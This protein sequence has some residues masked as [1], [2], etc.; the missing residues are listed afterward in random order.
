MAR[1]ARIK[2]R[3]KVMP[4]DVQHSQTE[5]PTARAL[6]ESDPD[7]TRVWIDKSKRQIRYSRWSTDLRYVHQ[8]PGKAFSFVG[9]FDG[10][11]KAKPYVLVLNNKNLLKS[12]PRV[13]NLN[14]KRGGYLPTMR[15]IRSPIVR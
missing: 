8:M 6:R 3:V 1:I 7:I 4:G 12:F 9:S 10:K 14:P 13:K 11:G 15:K 5:C 2:V